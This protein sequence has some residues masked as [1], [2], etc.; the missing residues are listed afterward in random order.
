MVTQ[1]P[2]DGRIKKGYTKDEY[3]QKVHKSRMDRVWEAV[4]CGSERVDLPGEGPFAGT[5][6]T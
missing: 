5:F 6:D 1:L 3:I 4:Q 2:S